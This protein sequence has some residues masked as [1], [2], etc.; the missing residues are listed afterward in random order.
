MTQ[1][2]KKAAQAKLTAIRYEIEAVM[3]GLGVTCG[4]NECYRHCNKA[5]DRIGDAIHEISKEIIE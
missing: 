3:L 4:A 2:E 1:D 5:R